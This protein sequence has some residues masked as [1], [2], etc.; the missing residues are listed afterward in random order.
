MGETAVDISAL[1]QDVKDKIAE[2]DL[3]LS[4]GRLLHTQQTKFSTLVL[5]YVVYI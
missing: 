3:E 4:E 1:P 5:Y 2:L